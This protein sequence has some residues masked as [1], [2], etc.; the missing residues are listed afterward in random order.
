MSDPTNNSVELSIAERISKLEKQANKARVMVGMVVRQI[1]L[2]KTISPEL[3]K[4]LRD[5]AEGED[6]AK[7]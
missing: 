2:D 6:N 5:F 1:E 3:I 4:D 7:S